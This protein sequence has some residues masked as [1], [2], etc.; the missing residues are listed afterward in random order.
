[1]PLRPWPFNELFSEDA[2]VALQKPYTGLAAQPRPRA[3]LHTADP[4]EYGTCLL[5]LQG[6]GLIR[7]PTAGAMNGVVSAVVNGPLTQKDAY[8]SFTWAEIRERGRWVGHRSLERYYQHYLYLPR[9][10]A[11]QV[12]PE[13][14]CPN[15]R[16]PS[17]VGTVEGDYSAYFFALRVP[18][19]LLTGLHPVGGPVETVNNVSLE[20]DGDGV[21]GPHAPDEPAG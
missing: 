17:P 4:A 21:C 13:L 7:F 15:A 9:D 20:Q 14:P 8:E 12:L 16:P 1:V 18:G 11:R 10:H 5:R 3:K 19:W 2:I 6:C